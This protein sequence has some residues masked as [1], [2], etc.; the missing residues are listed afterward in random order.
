MQECEMAPGDTFVLCTD[1]VSKATI[2]VGEVF[3]EQ[4][5]IEVL[6]QPYKCCQISCHAGL[7]SLG[8]FCSPE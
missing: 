5:V 6:K 8:Q 4:R 2:E 1:D 3:G 7:G